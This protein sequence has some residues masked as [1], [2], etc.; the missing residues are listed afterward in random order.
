MDKRGSKSAGESTPG[1]TADNSVSVLLD[2][3]RR[4]LARL[5]ETDNTRITVLDVRPFNARTV[6]KG[7]HPDCSEDAQQCGFMIGLQYDG[8]RY[9]YYAAGR[10]DGKAVAPCPP[11]LTM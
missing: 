3:A 6:T 10:A 1:P 11:L 8:R 7:C 4:D 5:L 9:A 2:L